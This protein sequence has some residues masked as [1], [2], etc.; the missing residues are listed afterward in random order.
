MAMDGMSFMDFVIFGGASGITATVFMDM[1][2]LFM[3]RMWG[4]PLLDYGLVGRWVLWMRKGQFMH[5]SIVNSG[6]MKGEKMLGWGVHY[7]IGVVFACIPVGLWGKTWVENPTL[8]GALIVGVSTIIAPF[9]VMQ[10][11]MGAGIAASKRPG[12]WLARFRSF[13]THMSYGVGLFLGAEGM[14]F[15][16]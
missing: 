15:L 5:Q 10:P 16:S 8:G 9:F 14:A 1:W 12:P 3:Q 13:V 11:C 7:L 4:V 6:D 2:A